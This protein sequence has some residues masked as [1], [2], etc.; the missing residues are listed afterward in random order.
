[1]KVLDLQCASLHIFEGWFASEEDFS[2]QH[3]GG[4]IQCPVCGES[5]I[6]KRLSAPRLNLGAT[7]P[8][9]ENCAHQSD[10]LASESMASAQS[11]W[12]QVCKDILSTTVDVGVEFTNTARKIHNGEQPYRAIRGHATQEQV[13]TLLDEGVDVLPLVIPD[14]LMEPHH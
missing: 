6:T 10:V 5:V 4:Q 1:M 14:F 8:T 7:Q 12:L 11:R 2:R 13:K 3:S 9:T